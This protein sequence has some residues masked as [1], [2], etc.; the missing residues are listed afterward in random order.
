MA[1]RLGRFRYGISALDQMALSIFGFGLNLYLV[2]A[3]SATHFGIL[4][5][6]LTIG[7]L[8]INLQNTLV[9]SPLSIH[10]HAAFDPDRE[11]RLEAA[12]SGVNLVL[13]LVIVIIA[14][15]VNSVLDTEWTP[16]DA[17]TAIAI[18]V[19]L[20]AGM[21]RE[22]HRSVAFSRNDM[23]M[24]IWTDAPYLT[25]TTLCLTAMMIWPNR[26]ANVPSALL[27]LSLG[28]IVSYA[29]VHS[30]LPRTGSRSTW[31]YWLRD[32]RPLMGDLS[33]AT[34]G[35]LA[36]HLQARAYVYITA[37]VV[38]AAGLASINVVGILFRPVRL[39]LFAWSR[40]ALPVLTQQLSSGRIKEFDRAFLTALGSAILASIVWLGVLRLGWAPIDR[41]FLL[42]RYPDAEILIISW[43]IAA[44]INVI[45][46]TV[47]IALQA[48]REFRFLAAATL[49]SA[50][51]TLLAT[52]AVVY[53]QGYTW[54]MYGTAFGN[55]VALAMCAVRLYT[56]RRKL[57]LQ[58]AAPAKST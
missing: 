17:F 46:F 4:S 1:R 2:R 52:A 57:I 31:R 28:C 18:P 50:P 44:A 58:S 48:A 14:V 15:A 30:R 37:N 23:P 16:H 26:F 51:I 13:T 5:W 9:T 20:A 22:Y 7:L 29:L 25:V 54:T 32:Y 43:A 12:I 38:S 11:R 33:W 10:L 42:G 40:S 55:A 45:D 34:I 47:S 53:W 39:M 49:V 35:G 41:Y 3:L 27:A 36:G 6:W 24:L 19:F 21:L 56:V 8:S